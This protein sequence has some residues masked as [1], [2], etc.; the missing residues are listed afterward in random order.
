MAA[1]C[2]VAGF[3]GGGGQEYATPDNGLWVGEAQ[4][5]E[6]A[7][8]IASLLAMDVSQQAARVQAGQATAALFDS[9]NFDAQLTAA[10]HQLLGD[11]AAAYKIGTNALLPAGEVLRAVGG[12][13]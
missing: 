1:G 11:A 4:L 7:L 13:A 5:P 2:L 9:A 10:W 3:T 12:A 6:L 8:A